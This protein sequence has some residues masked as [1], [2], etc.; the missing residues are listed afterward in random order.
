MRP[1]NTR[2]TTV[3]C[4]EETFHQRWQRDAFSACFGIVVALE[5]NHSSLLPNQTLCPLSA[6]VLSFSWNGTLYCICARIKNQRKVV[7]RSHEP[8]FH[9]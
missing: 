6:S 5:C 8:S 4:D 1:R 3:H 2:C 9:F 7:D